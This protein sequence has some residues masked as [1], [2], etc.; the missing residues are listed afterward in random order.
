[1]IKW[2]IG[3]SIPIFLSWMANRVR[4]YRTLEPGTDSNTGEKTLRYPLEFFILAII[5]LIILTVALHWY[6]FNVVTFIINNDKYTHIFAFLLLVFFILLV[7]MEAVV[8]VKLPQI[9]VV[10]IKYSDK[11]ITKAAS[12]IP[13][14]SI[15]EITFSKNIL[16]YLDE[17]NYEIVTEDGGKICVSTILKG[18]NAL[19][20]EL[21][22]Q[23]PD[24]C[25]KESKSIFIY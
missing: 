4:T 21:E 16:S 2:I 7:V 12:I 6:F 1:M 19:F 25:I 13:W 15:K 3:L 5:L 17:P 20:K 8:L 11:G 22:K 14:S 10:R 9:L 24:L 18:A 23:R